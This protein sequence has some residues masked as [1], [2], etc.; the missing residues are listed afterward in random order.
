MDRNSIKAETHKSRWRRLNPVQIRDK[1]QYIFR[2]LDVKE[3]FPTIHVQKGSLEVKR[4]GVSL[5]S[6]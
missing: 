3:S 2:I 1:R 5:H 6:K 4:E